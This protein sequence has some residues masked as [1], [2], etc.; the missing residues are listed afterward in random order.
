MKYY[1]VRDGTFSTVTP[2]PQERDPVL[3]LSV[4]FDFLQVPLTHHYGV[5]A[6]FIS[7]YHWCLS[8]VVLSP[9]LLF[10]L[11]EKGGKLAEKESRERGGVW[12]HLWELYY[13]GGCTTLWACN[14][15]SQSLSAKAISRCERRGE[16]DSTAKSTYTIAIAF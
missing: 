9:F 12:V 11:Q 8:Q 15:F 3:M 13:R 4:K 2:L 10:W 16:R 6:P 14:S 1:C 5:G 7:Q